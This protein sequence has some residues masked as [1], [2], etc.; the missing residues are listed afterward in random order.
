M[1]LIS[2]ITTIVTGMYPGATFML[3]SKFQANVTTLSIEA[4]AL[5]LIILDNELPKDNTI[6]I[7]DNVLK[8]SK[9]LISVLFLDSPE[10]TDLQ[11]E[12]LRAQAEV[13]ADRLAVQVYQFLPVKPQN[14]QRYKVT[15][16]FH[17]FA[18]DLTGVA[19]EMLVN[20]NEVV[21]FS[22]IVE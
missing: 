16:L 2:D 9:I 18:S 7:N 14:R 19:L 10:N 1:S 13:I 11:S 20:Y 6:A 4:T 5:P 12:A 21:N 15:P 22:N 17:V 3:S 8:N